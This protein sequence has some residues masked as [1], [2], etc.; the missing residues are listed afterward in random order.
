MVTVKQGGKEWHMCRPFAITLSTVKDILA[1]LN[2][3]NVD[4]PEFI[5]VQKNYSWTNFNRRYKPENQQLAVLSHEHK[6]E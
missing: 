3:R 1:A 2:W 4:W 6:P 5:A